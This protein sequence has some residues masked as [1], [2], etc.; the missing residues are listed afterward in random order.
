MAK[1]S[2]VKASRNKTSKSSLKDN[3][4]AATK[5]RKPELAEYFKQDWITC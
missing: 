1:M 4:N 2:S 5:P 3:N